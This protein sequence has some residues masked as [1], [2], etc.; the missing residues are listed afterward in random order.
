METVHNFK[1]GECNSL[2]IMSSED[3]LLTG[4]V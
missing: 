3:L 4:M 1:L 2:H